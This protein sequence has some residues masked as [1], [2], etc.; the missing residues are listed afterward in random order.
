M[1]KHIFYQSEG[2]EW[3]SAPPGHVISQGSAPGARVVT[4][5]GGGGNSLKL[6]FLRKYSPGARFRREANKSCQTMKNTCAFPSNIASGPAHENYYFF[7]FRRVAI[8]IKKR[9]K[10]EE[11][12]KKKSSKKKSLFE[13]MFF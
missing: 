13:K 5:R 2:W 11:I 10:F 3:I 4:C 9:N 1:K 6:V 8:F 7:R 12:C